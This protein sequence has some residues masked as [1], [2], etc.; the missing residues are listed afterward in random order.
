MLLSQ[1]SWSFSLDVFVPNRLPSF[2]IQPTAASRAGDAIRQSRAQ[3]RDRNNLACPVPDM[4][5]NI[6]H[7]GKVQKA[8]RT[9]TD[10][11]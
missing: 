3:H 9:L 1:A 4:L 6:A 7:L 5:V 8:I 2:F 11:T 10:S